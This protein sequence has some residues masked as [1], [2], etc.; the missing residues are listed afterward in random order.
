MVAG[1]I[2]ATRADEMY[3]SCSLCLFVLLLLSS[4]LNVG[5]MPEVLEFAK[6][7]SIANTVTA[8]ALVFRCLASS[9]NLARQFL[10]TADLISQ[11][12]AKPPKSNSGTLTI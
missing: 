1:P 5:G 8:Y 6:S 12:W 7:A 9:P 3:R 2:S 11:Y 4:G 10:V